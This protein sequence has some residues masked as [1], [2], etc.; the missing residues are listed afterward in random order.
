MDSKG[1]SPVHQGT[2]EDDQ[3]RSRQYESSYT[4]EV[5]SSSRSRSLSCDSKMTHLDVTA[6]EDVTKG[7]LAEKCTS[8]PLQ[9]WEPEEHIEQETQESG[10]QGTLRNRRGTKGELVA[11]R[12][13]SSTTHMHTLSIGIKKCELSSA[14]CQFSRV[15]HER[16]YKILTGFSLSLSFGYCPALKGMKP[17]CTLHHLSPSPA[18]KAGGAKTQ[19]SINPKQNLFLSLKLLAALLLFLI[20]AQLSFSLNI[21]WHTSFSYCRAHSPRAR[22]S[23]LLAEHHHRKHRPEGQR[24]FLAER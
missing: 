4:A 8:S 6:A 23:V 2:Q 1:D 22:G 5:Y 17:H 10:S 11:A 9:D 24:V 12:C 18:L 20:T 15:E 7:L 16:R 14:H 19:S 3:E 13:C 21:E